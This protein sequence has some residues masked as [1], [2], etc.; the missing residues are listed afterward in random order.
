LP[1][2]EQ[3]IFTPTGD[4]PTS[5]ALGAS[6]I[7]SS[8]AA[9]RRTLPAATSASRSSV[10]GHLQFDDSYGKLH[11]LQPLDAQYEDRGAVQPRDKGGNCVEGAGLP[12]NGAG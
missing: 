11:I 10:C 9:C 2:G 12:K 5:I 3:P 8:S 1:P 4:W 7:I 6:R